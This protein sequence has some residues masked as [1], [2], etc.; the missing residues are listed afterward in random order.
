[1]LFIDESVQFR[2]EIQKL[3]KQNDG[4]NEDDINYL[5]NRFDVNEGD[6]IESYRGGSDYRRSESGEKS[7]YIKQK[8]VFHF[9]KER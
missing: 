4:K 8:P 9:L 6:E 7:P 2:K 3:S 5:H 1:M